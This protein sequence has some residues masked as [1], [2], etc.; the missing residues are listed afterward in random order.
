[1]ELKLCAACG[2]CRHLTPGRGERNYHKCVVRNE[3]VFNTYDCDCNGELFESK[4]GNANEDRES[5]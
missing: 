3:L 1:M 2:N 5:V 4:R